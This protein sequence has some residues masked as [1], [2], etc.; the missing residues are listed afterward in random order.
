[1]ADINAVV[2]DGAALAA[3]GTNNRDIGIVYELE[4]DLPEVLIDVT[5]I[6][7]VV[8]NLVRNSLEALEAASEGRV[9]VRTEIGAT[10]F[11]QVAISDNGPGL[12]PD[13]AARLFQ[14]FVTTK[15]GGTGIGL[16][17]CKSIIESHGGRIAA[18][19]VEGGG[20]RFAFSVPVA[21]T[22]A[23]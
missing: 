12:A 7:Q 11:V 19:P 8:L 6:Q 15:S 13:V 18:T 9:T 23:C 5:Q 21:P 20:A 2:Q 1:V 10:G 16:S 22:A 3:I 14:P 4:S 17:I